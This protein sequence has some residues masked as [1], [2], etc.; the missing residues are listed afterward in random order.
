MASYSQVINGVLLRCALLA[1]L[2]WPSAA[3]GWTFYRWEDE[4]GITHFTN[5]ITKIPAFY[6]DRVEVIEPRRK[7]MIPPTVPPASAQEAG[8]TAPEAQVQEAGTVAPEAQAE[9]AVTGAAEAPAA[10]EQ[11]EQPPTPE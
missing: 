4:R 2:L 1:L 9:E 6:R 11:V 10:P 5:N 3:L 7:S 8:P